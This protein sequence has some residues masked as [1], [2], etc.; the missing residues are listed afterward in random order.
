L[1]IDN[2]LISYTGKTATT[3]TGC[4]RAATLTQYCLG[5]TRSFTAGAAAAHAINTGVIIV[6]NTASPTLSH[7]GSAVICDGEFDT[8]RG[9][10]FN[11]QRTA[12]PITTATT[13]AFLIRLAPSVS[14]SQI[15]DLGS[16]DL[17]NRSQLL[18]NAVG[19]QTY[20]AA[21]T[22]GSVIV[23]GVLNPGNF[24][25]ATW[26]PLNLTAAGGQPSLAQVATSV[27]WSTGT[28]AIPGEQV[29]AFAATPNSDSRLELV[30]LKELTNAPIGGVGAY[31]NGPDI[32]AVNVRIVSGT[33]NASV[34]LRWGEAQA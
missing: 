32:L 15:G 27:T 25:S 3:F 17:L 18:L 11:Y 14:N 5:A 30:E 21:T 10:I 13:T 12:L 4:T 31:P 34:L 24:T 19:I 26:T 23:E 29:F 1:Y 16:R 20:G 33:A 7:W 9:Y 22:P 2:E 6:S 28:S 8:D